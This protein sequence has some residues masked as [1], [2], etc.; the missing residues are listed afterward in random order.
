MQT[1]NLLLSYRFLDFPIRINFMN[2]NILQ[3]KIRAQ[4]YCFYKSLI[5]QK[6]VFRINVSVFV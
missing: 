1:K 2:E 6:L 4:E 5:R 3:P